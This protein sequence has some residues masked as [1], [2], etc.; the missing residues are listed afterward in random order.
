MP[1]KN[2]WDHNG[3]LITD[4]ESINNTH[5]IHALWKLRLK[6]KDPDQDFKKRFRCAK[7]LD[8]Y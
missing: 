4:F 2:E 1:F 5:N 7:I 3:K 8:N 6:K